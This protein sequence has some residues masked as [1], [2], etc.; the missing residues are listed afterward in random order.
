MA[1]LLCSRGLRL[2]FVLLPQLLLLL[3]LLIMMRVQ[4]LGRRFI[5]APIVFSQHSFDMVSLPLCCTLFIRH[6]LRT[7]LVCF[8]REHV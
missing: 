6:H 7:V 8:N 2:E 1:R 5:C 3:L 4:V